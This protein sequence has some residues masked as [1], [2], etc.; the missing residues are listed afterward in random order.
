VVRVTN[1]VTP[2]GVIATLA[3][4]Y[5]TSR[6]FYVE[7]LDLFEDAIRKHHGWGGAV[8]LSNVVP[9]YRLFKEPG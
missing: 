6:A 7:V 8:Q 9:P 2:P 5:H 1:R 3:A 4:A